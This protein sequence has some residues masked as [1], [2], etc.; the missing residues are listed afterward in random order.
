MDS[1]HGHHPEDAT[2]QPALLQAKMA[3]TLSRRSVYSLCI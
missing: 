2:G 1:P 3:E